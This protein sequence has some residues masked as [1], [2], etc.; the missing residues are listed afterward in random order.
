MSHAQFSNRSSV[1]SQYTVRSTPLNTRP[2]T[3]GQDTNMASDVEY[4]YLPNNCEESP[5]LSRKT[6]RWGPWPDREGVP[7]HRFPP[8]DMDLCEEGEEDLEGAESPT[9]SVHSPVIA[10]PSNDI[11]SSISPTLRDYKMNND[12]YHRVSIFMFGDMEPAE[13]MEIVESE[14]GDSPSSN[15]SVTSHVSSNSPRPSRNRKHLDNVR[16]VMG[17]LNK[18]QKKPGRVSPTGNDSTNSNVGSSKT[19]GNRQEDIYDDIVKQQDRIS[20]IHSQNSHY[21]AMPGSPQ[22]NHER[23]FA[24]PI[25][26]VNERRDSEIDSLDKAVR[27]VVKAKRLSSRIRSMV[28]PIKPDTPIPPFP[29]PCTPLTE[30]VPNPIR[31]IF[32]PPIPKNYYSMSKPMS[33]LRVPGRQ[34]GL[35]INVP[36]TIFEDTEDGS[37]VPASPPCIPESPRSPTCRRKNAS[38]WIAPPLIDLADDATSKSIIVERP[39]VLVEHHH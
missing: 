28:I 4:I 9:I 31:F 27:L 23:F 14:K 12:T 18:I 25:P 13:A 29:I 10:S 15:S 36:Q 33:H 22:S 35:N 26:E 17:V 7:G 21:C 32:E 6:Q 30:S 1:A 39:G 16:N 34:P 24:S 37:E 8:S 38:S 3:P 2:N 5:Q 11:T 19:N 20:Y